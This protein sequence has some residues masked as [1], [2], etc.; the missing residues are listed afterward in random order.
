MFSKK[1]FFFFCAAFFFAVPLLFAEYNSFGIPDSSEIRKKIGR[2][3]FE[4]P[5]SAL[6]TFGTEIYKNSVGIE[7]ELRFE[8]QDDVFL[9][10]V[11]PAS[12]GI[13][14]RDK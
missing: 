6:R 5:L 11:A 14:V 8:E 7:F 1:I 12:D 4:G 9:V 13:L 2:E 3:W 10:I